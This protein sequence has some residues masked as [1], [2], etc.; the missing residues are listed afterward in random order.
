MDGYSN[1]K[2]WVKE[3]D[4]QL[5][6]R[7]FNIGDWNSAKTCFEKLGSH[8]DSKQKATESSYRLAK[9]YMSANDWAKAK[10]EL[11]RLGS[12]NDSAD[13]IKKCDY[14]LAKEVYSNFVD[15]FKI[16]DTEMTRNQFLLDDA[17]T[18]FKA[19]SG[20]EDSDAYL[21]LIDYQNAKWEN[22]PFEIDKLRPI[23][24]KLAKYKKQMRS[25]RMPALTVFLL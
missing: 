25:V 18:K 13:M 22:T 1:S 8:R 2:E 5:A 6:C 12:Y 10:E 4:Y 16:N 9:T 17:T 20:Y 24:Q 21:A 11:V 23:F 3:C 15:S 7:H 19:L 14:E